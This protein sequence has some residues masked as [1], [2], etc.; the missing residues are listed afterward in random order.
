[1]NINIFTFNGTL[2][3]TGFVIRLFLFLTIIPAAFW[4]AI[5]YIYKK[6]GVINS[7]GITNIESLQFIVELIT[8]LL[9]I[10]LIIRRL[11]D[12]NW[13]VKISRNLHIF[14]ISA[15]LI[16]IFLSIT[17]PEI[18]IG[19]LESFLFMPFFYLYYIFLVL[20]FKKGRKD[21]VNNGVYQT[22]KNIF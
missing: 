4:L 2:S 20:F 21:S 8:I 12:I 11:R 15:G 10:P 7:I 19:I 5:S 9:C 17:I 16:I 1:M 18:E 3:R 14:M 22:I 6:D 13:E